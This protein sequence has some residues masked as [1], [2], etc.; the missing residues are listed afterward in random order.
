M[1]SFCLRPVLVT[2][3]AVAI[4]AC[5]SS[6]GPDSV[7]ERRDLDV[8]VASDS[9]QSTSLSAEAVYWG[10]GRVTLAVDDPWDADHRF[11]HPMLAHMAEA[12]GNE[13]PAGHWT[14]SR[15]ELRNGD[16]AA[17]A[18]LVNRDAVTPWY[19]LD[20]E[21]LPDSTSGDETV[22]VT[23]HFNDDRVPVTGEREWRVR[24]GGHP[25][26]ISNDLEARVA[27]I[28]GV[29]GRAMVDGELM[30]TRYLEVE[31]RNTGNSRYTL[32]T[33]RSG[34]GIN[35]E[36]ISMDNGQQRHVAAGS[37]SVVEVPINLPDRAERRLNGPASLQRV[38]VDAMHAFQWNGPDAPLGQHHEN[39]AEH[40]QGSAYLVLRD[41]AG[42]ER[43]G[44]ADA[45]ILMDRRD[46]VDDVRCR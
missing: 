4:A 16:G 21:A 9:V 39:A 33:D 6:P 11:S 7:V 14:V 37:R 12:C 46:T 8:S 25:V 19:D 38:S 30:E 27:G 20:G 10:D 2:G 24:A 31:L 26:Q 40:F 44:F 42:R 22:H 13:Q 23:L 36:L 45:T 43:T 3:A 41:H 34:G 35:D 29:T 28:S 17:T 32:D 18:T 15:A 5:S 1:P